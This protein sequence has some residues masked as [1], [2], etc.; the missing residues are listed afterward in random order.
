MKKR[1][2][3]GGVRKDMHMEIC[4]R[5]EWITMKEREEERDS[6][7]GR[8]KHIEKQIQEQKRFQVELQYLDLPAAHD[9]LS[10]IIQ[11]PISCFTL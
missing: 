4:G 5:K 6:Q 3:E 8:N 11:Q 7:S 10:S 1:Q 9:L 2:V